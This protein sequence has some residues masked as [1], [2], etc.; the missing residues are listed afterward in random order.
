MVFENDYV[1][2]LCLQY[3]RDRDFGTY[4]RICQYT[5]NLMDSI[6]LGS[7]F[8]RHVSFH[9]LCSHLF[10]QLERWIDKWTP[11]NGTLYSYCS[12]C[13]KHGCISYVTREAQLRQRQVLTGDI[14]LETIGASYTMDFSGEKD[15]AERIRSGIHIR[16]NDPEIREAIKYV[17]EEILLN[18]GVRQRKIM[19]RTMECAFDLGMHTEASLGRQEPVEVAKFIIDW[20][21]TAVRQ[22]WLDHHTPP[23]TAFDIAR[24]QSRFSFLPDLVNCI[25]IENAAKAMSVFSGVSIRFPTTAG[26]EKTK[27]LAN[28]YDA[29]LRE[30][31]PHTVTYWSKKLKIGE[32]RLASIFQSWA[33]NA[34]TG[35]LEDVVLD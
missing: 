24:I 5:K 21:Q 10:L 19:L 8:N 30:P 2:S 23:I 27:Q 29:Y 12:T 32:E 15:L 13:I 18:G 20:T 26:W 16:W 1:E 17:T 33:S 31:D 34:Q 22:V 4:H 14:P 7:K 6:I 28:A 35:V 9:D 25:G 11:G 3:K